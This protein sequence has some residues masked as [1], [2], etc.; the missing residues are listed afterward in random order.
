MKTTQILRA[1]MLEALERAGQKIKNPNEITFEELAERFFLLEERHRILRTL[2][3][4]HHS[5]SPPI[6]P[7]E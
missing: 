3:P 7:P 1:A 2:G 5:A 6:R 4:Q